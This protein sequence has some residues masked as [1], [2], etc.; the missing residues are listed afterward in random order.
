MPILTRKTSPKRL[1]NEDIIDDCKYVIQSEKKLIPPSSEHSSKQ[2]SPKPFKITSVLEEVTSTLT[3]KLSGKE[4]V[5]KENSKLRLMID[6]NT[7]FISLGQ[8]Q[9]AILK[10]QLKS[11]YKIE[12]KEKLL[13]KKHHIESKESKEFS[14][15][16]L[17]EVKGSVNQLSRTYNKLKQGNDSLIDQINQNRKQS[18]QMLKSLEELCHQLTRT[19]LDK[20]REEDSTRKQHR[21]VYNNEAKQLKILKEKAVR[22]QQIML[23][24]NNKH[25][26]SSM[27]KSSYVKC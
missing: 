23:K 18:N 11:N 7:E 16:K 9:Q 15:K 14:D 26:D 2:G 12:E 6:K 24:G 19:L 21:E 3:A 10:A 4:K 27:S 25:V 1:P 8:K 13:N 5:E 20:A 17:E 22:I